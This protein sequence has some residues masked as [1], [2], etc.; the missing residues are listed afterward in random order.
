MLLDSNILIYSITNEHK[1]LLAPYI[2]A[3]GNSVSLLTKLEVLGFHRLQ[4]PEKT[5]FAEIFERLEVLPIDEETVDA[6]ITLRQQ[7]SMTVGDAIIAA[8]ALRYDLPL[9]TRNTADFKWIDGLV[10]VNPFEG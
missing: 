2:Y 9:V 5:L 8:T 1:A 7:K 4:E 10:L 6:A 3:V